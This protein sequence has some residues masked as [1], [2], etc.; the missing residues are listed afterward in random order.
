MF[1]ATAQLIRTRIDQSG[2]QLPQIVVAV[3]EIFGEPFEESWNSGFVSRVHLVDWVNQSLSEE[4]SPQ[5][6]NDS[7]AEILL[8]LDR[9]FDQLFAAAEGWKFLLVRLG[10]CSRWLFNHL[11]RKKHDFGDILFAVRAEKSDL[12]FVLL[13]YFALAASRSIE[14][15]NHAVEVFLLPIVDQRMVVTFRA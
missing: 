3:R 13:T 10:S 11:S 7:A 14:E 5:S 1:P 8:L 4:I 9:D 15:R 2:N 12:A 6:I